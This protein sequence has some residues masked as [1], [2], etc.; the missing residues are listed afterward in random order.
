MDEASK[1]MTR[2]EEVEATMA[3]FGCPRFDAE[4]LVAI[5]RGESPGD[6]VASFDELQTRP[7]SR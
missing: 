2:E 5:S 7:E 1:M 6:C 4:E 3:I